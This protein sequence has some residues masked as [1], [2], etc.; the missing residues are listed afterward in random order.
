MKNKSSGKKKDALFEA[1][2][3]VRK[4]VL[5][6]E[7]VDRQFASASEF[8]M[9]IQELATSGTRVARQAVERHESKRAGM[10]PRKR[11]KARR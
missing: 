8:T 10:A 3:K 4:Q 7:Y 2:L 5:T 6:S 11:G 1:G 9:P